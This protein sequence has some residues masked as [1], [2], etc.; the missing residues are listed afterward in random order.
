MPFW[1]GQRSTGDFTSCL[2]GLF[3][4]PTLQPHAGTCRHTVPS[5]AVDTAGGAGRGSGAH[6]NSTTQTVLTAP[7]ATHQLWREGLTPAWRLPIQNAELSA[8][9]SR[10]GLKTR[11]WFSHRVLHRAAAAAAGYKG[12]ARGTGTASVSGERELPPAL[13]G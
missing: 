8:V 11:Q 1:W 3:P 13:Q 12:R 10:T 2:K 4:S 6:T 7:R 9:L 5:Q